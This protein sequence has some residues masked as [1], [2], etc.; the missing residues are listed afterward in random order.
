MKSLSRLALKSYPLPIEPATP[1]PRPRG[2]I[3]GGELHRIVVHGVDAGWLPH[4]QQS[5][6]TLIGCRMIA[7]QRRYPN[8]GDGRKAAA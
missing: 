2:L 1:T 3:V 4:R 5:A 8:W 7:K 6:N